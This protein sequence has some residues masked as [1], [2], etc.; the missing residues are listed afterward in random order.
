MKNI[1]LEERIIPLVCTEI[2]IQIFN[3]NDKEHKKEEKMTK[4]H[5]K[6]NEKQKI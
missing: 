2:T 6:T 4:S 1:I 5:L 3:E